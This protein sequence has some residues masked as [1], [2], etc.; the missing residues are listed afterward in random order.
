MFDIFIP[1]GAFAIFMIGLVVIT[2]IGLTAYRLICYLLNRDW[3][4]E[5]FD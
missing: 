4:D 1:F 3:N 5:R 2:V